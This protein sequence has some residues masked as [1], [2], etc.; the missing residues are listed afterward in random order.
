MARERR[1]ACR[2]G[3]RC[4][5]RTHV[6]VEDHA[7]VSGRRADCAREA[8]AFV[9][10]DVGR[11]E[12]GVTSVRETSVPPY[13]PAAPSVRTRSG[14]LA[15]A[16]SRAVPAVGL[17]AGAV[18]VAS[19]LNHGWVPHDDGTLA[20]S[21]QRVL[22]GEL[23]HR[24]FAEL[25][26]GGLSF[27]NAG[28]LWLTGGNLFWLRAPMF[29]LFLAHL[30]C[31]YLIARR[32]ASTTVAT[33]AA[34]FA[35]AW[36]PPVYSAAIPSWYTLYLAV[37]GAYFLVR[38]HE[39]GRRSWLFAAGV[40]GGLSICCKIT[41]VWY[42]LAVAVYLVYSAQERPGGSGARNEGSAARVARRVVFVGVPAASALFVGAV[43]AEK[44]GPAEAVN[45]LL[46]VVAI[47]ALTAWSGFRRDGEGAGSLAS[48]FGSAFPFLAGVT[49]PIF[50]LAA[51]YLASGSLGDLYTGL[52]VTP[53]GRLESGYYGTAAP[54]AFVFA[55]PVLVVLLAL[56]KRTRA[57]RNADVAASVALGAVLLISTVTLVGYLTMWYTTTSLLPV[58]VIVGVAVLARHAD[59]GARARQTSVFLL[60][61]LTAF[62][63][64]VQFPFGAPVYFCFVAPLAVLAW[65]A[66]FRHTPLHESSS[67]IF[68]SLLLASIVAF[69]FVVD[70]SVLYQDG[71][72]PNGNP[73]TVILDSDR[74]WIRVSPTH[75]AV[76]LETSA[77][78]QAHARG[79]YIYA[80]PDTPEI[81]ALTGLRNPTRSLFDYLD[82]SDSARGANLLRTL[83]S[84]GVTAIVIN[85]QPGFSRRL[86]PR[87]VARL[88]A[89]Y[90]HHER[91]GAF[92]VR[93][94][95]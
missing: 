88:R 83:R 25:Y 68:P 4:S 24:D 44:L 79:R 66:M 57:A 56:R 45:L 62:V 84:H 67:R 77:L 95:A 87:T 51:P 5:E 3:R 76:Y 86:E 47:C 58:G 55:V 78:L 91:V 27:L 16:A 19:Q 2:R 72:R 65:L 10:S 71:T 1:H 12:R 90:P 81:Y 31:V 61:A 60:L 73:Q 21:A 70:H 6:A 94:K 22:V 75:R 14:Q 8:P 48:L 82:P 32:F 89:E 43:L 29:L 37:I 9:P 7:C 46:P 18:F 50:L 80:G 42:V 92:D 20:Q 23:P 35:V 41:G 28:V 93:W 39:T 52:F 26:T 34:L 49:L 64:L 13:G 11:E 36:G 40:A 59:P 63:A 38:H 15:G 69:G 17:V 74:A 53:R 85:A 30:G 54:A 33:L